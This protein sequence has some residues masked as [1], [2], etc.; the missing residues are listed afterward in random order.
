MSSP[1]I[2]SFTL[3]FQIGQ[4]VATKSTRSTRPATKAVMKWV[5]DQPQTI[6]QKSASSSNTSA[7]TSPTCSTDT[8]KRW[9]WLTPARPLSATNSRSTTTSPRRDGY[10][11]LVAFSGSVIGRTGPDSVDRG[12]HEPVS[13][14]CGP[15]RR[16]RLP[17][18]IVTNKVPTGFDQPLLWPPYADPQTLRHHRG[19]TT[20]RLNRTYGPSGCSKTPSSQ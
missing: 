17:V 3:A 10:R 7:R 11:T 5:G 15:L 14:T 9:W 20:G 4:K 12:E 2:H 18:M 19:V 1:A 16:W 13:V 6:S 8:P